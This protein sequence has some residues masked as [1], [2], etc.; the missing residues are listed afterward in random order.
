MFQAEVVEKMKTHIVGSITF[1]PRKWRRLWNNVGKYGTAWQATH[2]SIIR[3]IACWITWAINTGPE[4]YVFLF[5]FNN[6]YAN[7]PQRYVYTY[8]ACLAVSNI[9]R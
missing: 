1:S 2:G 8:I 5:H 7:A 4:E 9:S 3:R 6:G